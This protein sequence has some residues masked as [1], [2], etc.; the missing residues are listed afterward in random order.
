MPHCCLQAGGTNVARFTLLIILWAI[1]GAMGKHH[2][3]GHH[4]QPEACSRPGCVLQGDQLH[5]LPS[6]LRV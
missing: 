5:G 4:A 2:H 1:Y 3:P 6:G